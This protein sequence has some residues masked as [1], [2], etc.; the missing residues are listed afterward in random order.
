MNTELLEILGELWYDTPISVGWQ[1]NIRN[2]NDSY[3][4][5]DDLEWAV[6]NTHTHEQI[7]FQW[8]IRIQPFVMSQIICPGCKELL[9]QRPD[10]RDVCS[11]GHV[12]YFL[13]ETAAKEWVV[14]NHNLCKFSH[15]CK[16]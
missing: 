3:A 16:T 8:Y 11:E 14:K 15:P 7:Q 13:T 4:M 10:N 6:Y 9:R 2:C 1:A 5:F 12:F